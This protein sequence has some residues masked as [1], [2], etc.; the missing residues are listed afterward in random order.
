MEPEIVFDKPPEFEPEREGGRKL[1]GSIFSVTVNT[2]KRPF[3]LTPQGVRN[4]EVFRRADLLQAIQRMMQ[5]PAQRRT[6]FR[7]LPPYQNDVYGRRVIVRLHFGR[8]TSEL[9]THRMGGRVHANFVIRVIHYSRLQIDPVEMKRAILANLKNRAIRNLHLNVVGRNWHQ[10]TLL[11]YINK[12]RAS[13]T[14][15]EVAQRA[16]ELASLS[17]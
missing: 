9:G 12:E 13:T 7:F 2:N 5:N 11:R 8:P 4:D 1:A 14:G 3:G 6:L 17:I 15:R 10:I 16:E